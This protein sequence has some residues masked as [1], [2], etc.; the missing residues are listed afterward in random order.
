MDSGNQF[1]VAVVVSAMFSAT[2]WA[3]IKTEAVE[4]KHGKTVLQGFFAYDDAEVLPKKRPGILVVHEWW[5]HN[6]H[7]R[8]QAVRLAKEGYV[9]FA[10]DMFGKGKVAEH[11]KDAQSFMMEATK[12]PKVVKARFLAALE[13]LKKHKHV[14]AKKLGSIGYC[15]G[16][17]VALNMARA[18]VDLAAV[19]TFHAALAGTEKAKPGKVRP[20]ILVLNGADDPM[21]PAAAVAEFEAEML[22]AKANAR[23][24]N[25]PGARHAFTNPDA[26]KKGIPALAYSAEADKAS[27]EAMRGMLLEVFGVVAP[28]GASPAQ[29]APPPDAGAQRK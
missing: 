14:D 6:E 16:G 10:L 25:L 11:P 18:G 20:R 19:V 29:A 3:E 13:V 28:Q 15:F 4:Y 12:D 26:D 27:W 9:A 17:N 24:Q 21:V 23:V 5:G 2:A 22:A 8:N 1:R 7:A